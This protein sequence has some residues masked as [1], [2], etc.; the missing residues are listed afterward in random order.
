MSGTA[1]DVYPS[2]ERHCIPEYSEKHGD[3]GQQYKEH[4][5]K[6]KGHYKYIAYHS[7]P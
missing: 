2:L 7:A 1:V 5:R 6:L 4:H 3:G